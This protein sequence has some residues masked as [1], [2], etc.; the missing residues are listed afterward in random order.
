MPKISQLQFSWNSAECLLKVNWMFTESLFNI[1]WKSTESLSC[2]KLIRNL[3][4]H[5][6]KG[7]SKPFKFLPKTYQKVHKTNAYCTWEGSFKMFVAFRHAK[8][9]ECQKRTV[10]LNLGGPIHNWTIKLLTTGWSST[11]NFLRHI[12]FLFF[13]FFLQT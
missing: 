4:E 3:L 2:Q 6:Q 11:M 13:I 8:F 12:I 10:F 9:E 5:S 1:Y 7:Y